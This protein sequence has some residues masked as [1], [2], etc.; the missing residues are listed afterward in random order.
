[1]HYILLL[2]LLK[3]TTTMPIANVDLTNSLEYFRLIT[4]QGILAWNYITNDRFTSTGVLTFNPQVPGHGM[5]VAN[6]LISGNGSLVR[7]IP[8]AGITFGKIKTS[9]LQ[10]SG[11][12]I[13]NSSSI[14]G[15]SLTLGSTGSI[16]LNVD[17]IN[18]ITNS[19]QDLV[20]SANSIL[21]YL[22]NVSANASQKTIGTFVPAVGGTGITSYSNGRTLIGNSGTPVSNTFGANIGISVTSVAGQI[23]IGANLIQSIGLL[24]TA[25]SGTQT[26]ISRNTLD[27]G[28]L[29][30][31][32][33]IQLSDDLTVQSTTLAATANSLN[34]IN[35]LVGGLSGG[36]VSNAFGRLTNVATYNAAGRYVFTVPENFNFGIVTIV[37]GGGGGSS[38]NTMN[39]AN[40]CV[41]GSG[42]GGG[43]YLRGIFTRADIIALGDDGAG[44]PNTINITVGGGGPAGLGISFISSY[45]SSAGVGANGGDTIFGGSDPARWMFRANGGPAGWTNYIVNQGPETFVNF[46]YTSTTSN[47]YYARA[48]SNSQGIGTSLAECSGEAGHPGWLHFITKVY[49]AKDTSS[50]IAGISGYGGAGGGALSGRIPG[51]RADRLG[52][53]L[54][55]GHD[56]NTFQGG[57]FSGFNANGAIGAGGSG[58]AAVGRVKNALQQPPDWWQVDGGSGANGFVQ[59]EIYSSI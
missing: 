56:E 1:M 9:A 8:F 43:A 39:M 41:F 26:S 16:T 37:G 22:A 28:S 42:G 34:A 7:S 24:F 57:G 14:R 53:Q 55:R 3:K 6:G 45:P 15:G 52:A 44:S 54:T 46:R 33:P 4:N 21:T 27:P 19:R 2:N 10:N 29:T 38:A 5:N 36:G 18:S 51:I 47:V 50:E 11:I 17:V 13:S 58:G 48:S 40:I 25:L 32:G 30:V 59:I 31:T 35:K 20:L 49:V 12:A 23:T